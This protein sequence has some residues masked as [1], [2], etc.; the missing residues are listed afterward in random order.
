M[1]EIDQPEQSQEKESYM[2][3]LF[4]MSG[5]LS[6]VIKIIVFCIPIVFILYSV[7]VFI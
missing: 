6:Y 2:G 3:C 7:D 1:A 4:L 5:F